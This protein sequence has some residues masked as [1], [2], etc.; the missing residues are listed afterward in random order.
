M[1]LEIQ[2][3]AVMPLVAPLLPVAMTVAIPTERKVSMIALRAD[4]SA[5]QGASY[6]VEPPR[7]MFTAAD[8]KTMAQVVDPFQAPDLIGFISENTV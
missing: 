3:G 5:S 6:V 8:V 4:S 1:A 2:A 7:L